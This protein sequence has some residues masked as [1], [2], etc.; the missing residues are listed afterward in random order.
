LPGDTPIDEVLLVLVPLEYAGLA[1]T[2]AR[3]KA[4]K[5]IAATICL[6]LGRPAEEPD[7]RTSRV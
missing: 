6:M 2:S 7:I 5:M 3:I 1:A 4:N